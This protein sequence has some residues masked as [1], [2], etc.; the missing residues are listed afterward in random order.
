MEQ[1]MVTIDGYGEDTTDNYGEETIDTYG[2]KPNKWSDGTEGA[3]VIVI[4]IVLDIQTRLVRLSVQRII[5]S[6]ILSN[7]ISRLHF[8]N[9]W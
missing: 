8:V 5:F 7:F 6:G 1:A 3:G 4:F 2:E 9:I